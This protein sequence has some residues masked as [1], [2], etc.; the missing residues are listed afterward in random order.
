MHSNHLEGVFAASITPFTEDYSPDTTAL[1]EH[2]RFLALRGCHGIL[3]LGTTGEGPSLS[4]S[5]RNEILAAACELRQ[6]RPEIVLLAGTGTPSLEESISLTRSAFNLGLDG[7]V[8]LPPY[9]FKNVDVDG[10]LKWFETIITR[11]VPADGKLFGYHIPPIS[12]IE[13]PIDLLFRLKDRFPDQ[14]AGIKDSSADPK[15]AIRLGEAFSSD[16]I[17]FTG[18]DALF[19]HA[20]QNHARGCI[21]A[22]ANIVSPLIR[23]IWDNFR[24]GQNVQAKQQQLSVLR[25]LFDQYSPAP[26]LIKG[27]LGARYHS[28][29]G[30]VMPP[31]VPLDDKRLQE[32]LDL[33]TIELDQANV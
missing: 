21:T 31:L 14:F 19:L 30:Q 6:E 22:A 16:L 7:V 32:A 18:N 23:S 33:I 11:A 2:L 5:Q 4:P 8:V 20:L 24:A 17:V 15:F 9:Y 27:L 26:A 1:R 12:K 13:L 29:V 3:L 25:H 28:M 10:L